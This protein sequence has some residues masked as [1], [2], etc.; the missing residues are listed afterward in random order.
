MKLPTT[1]ECI[2]YGSQIGLSPD[3]SEH[4]FDH[5][6]SNGWRVGRNPMKS[7]QA[8]MRNWLRNNRKWNGQ[9]DFSPNSIRDREREARVAMGLTRMDGTAQIKGA[10]SAWSE[11]GLKSVDRHG[12]VIE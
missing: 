9:Q 6:E 10:D 4:F 7:W 3:D 12:R 11:L 8:A 5:F 1:E 2:E